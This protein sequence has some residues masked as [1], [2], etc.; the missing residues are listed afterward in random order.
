MQVIDGQTYGVMMISV[1]IISS[2]VQW[3]VK[4]LYDPSRKYVGYQ[5]RNIMSLKP[6]SELRMLVTIHKPNHITPLT[7]F[8]DL[9]CPTAE[10]PMTVEVLHLVE[11][12][13]RALPVFIHHCLQRQE[14]SSNS[15]RKSYSDDIIIAFD[16]F[17]HENE[18]AASVNT[19][20]AISPA[21]LM[22]E[23]VCN[24][25]LDKVASMII[26]PFHQ[27][28]SSD[29]GVESDDKN[30]RTLNLRVLEIAPC[31]VGILV[32]RA[33]RG[34]SPPQ[35]SSIGIIYLGGEDDDEVLCLAKRAIKNPNTRLVVYHLV[36][37]EYK[38]EL[39]D[40][41]MEG[42]SDVLREVKNTQNVK[43]KEVFTKDGSETASFL[44]D[45]AKEHDFFIVGRRH[46]MESPQTD[47]LT[48]WSEFPELGV[49]GDFLSSPDLKSH[50]SILVVQQQLSRQTQNAWVL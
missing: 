30:I 26:L 41:M 12:V 23:D 42:E 8:L 17:E 14:S 36:A 43:F 22:Y 10:D 38:P 48:A 45:I 32:T 27:R 28:W 20:T 44:G 9:C 3:C 46:G 16:I 19:Y 34:S 11:L 1:M 24:L 50:A 33:S 29:G 5:K 40:L 49:V 13:G 6:H 47:G 15:F 31:S 18:N 25:A 7:E 37:K 21:E 4:L 35:F 2:I 39:K